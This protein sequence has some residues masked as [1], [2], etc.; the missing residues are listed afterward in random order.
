MNPIRLS[1]AA[2]GVIAWLGLALMSASFIVM[3]LNSQRF[4]PRAIA[5]SKRPEP[6][7]VVVLDP[8]HGGQDSGAMAGNFLEKDLT[9]DVAQRIDRLLGARGVAT[10]MTRI[11]DAYVSL[12]DL[13]V[14]G[15]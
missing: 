10:L 15:Q 13:S 7:S 11:G 3:V 6:V 8:G 12:A 9:L 14:H 5:R 1:K 2:A 4:L